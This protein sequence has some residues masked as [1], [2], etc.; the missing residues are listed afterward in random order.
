[1]AAQYDI[2]D[3]KFTSKSEMEATLGCVSVRPSASAVF[4]IDVKNKPLNKYLTRNQNQGFDRRQ[5]YDFC[6]FQIATQGMQEAKVQIGELWCVYDIS[7][8]KPVLRNIIQEVLTVRI[9]TRDAVTEAKTI[10]ILPGYGLSTY[11]LEGT[12]C[13][14]NNRAAIDLNGWVD[15][16]FRLTEGYL[17]TFRLSWSV[18][19]ADVQQMTDTQAQLLVILHNGGQYIPDH[20][21]NGPSTYQAGMSSFVKNAAGDSLMCEL[22]FSYPEG[23]GP[24]DITFSRV[25]N[26]YD[27]SPYPQNFDYYNFIAIDQIDPTTS[28]VLATP[29]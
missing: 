5:F 6:N 14:T 2:S 28:L 19:R 21:K 7:F 24:V 13:Y 3:P 25:G 10:R 22:T 9:N 29:Q 17:G 16:R 12:K 1:M 15:N 18:C 4:N 8:Y 11:G 23:S 27:K 20:W 26:P